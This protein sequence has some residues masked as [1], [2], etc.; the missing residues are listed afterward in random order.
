MSHWEE[1]L[2]IDL[3]GQHI[4]GKGDGEWGYAFCLLRIE[5]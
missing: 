5:I 2:G 4:N 3:V 1:E